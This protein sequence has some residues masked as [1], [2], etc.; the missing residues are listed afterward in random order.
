MA[1]RLQLV[2]SNYNAVGQ[3]VVAKLLTFAGG[4]ANALGDHDG[5]AD[6]YTIFTVTGTV[7]ARVWGICGDT[8]VGAATIEC[9]ITGDTAR[10]IAQIPDATA[11]AVGEVWLDATPTL[12]AEA[13]PAQ[14][15]LSNNVILTVGTA[16]ITAGNITMY[17]MWEPV[18]AGSNVKAGTASQTG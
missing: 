8:L 18:S 9:G 1:Q 13:V 17:C 14:I 12:K 15:I 3:S 16:N 11:L 2:D 4:T 10:I 7:L 5:T 6:P